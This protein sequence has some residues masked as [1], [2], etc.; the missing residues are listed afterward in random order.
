M[1]GPENGLMWQGPKLEG[2]KLTHLRCQAKGLSIHPE[3]SG[4]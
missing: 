3:V 2:D 4:G 1:Y